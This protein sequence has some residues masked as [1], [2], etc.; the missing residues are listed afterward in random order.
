MRLRSSCRAS[1][2]AVVLLCRGTQP[3]SGRGARAEALRDRLRSITPS[4]QSYIV[5]SNTVCP[6]EALVTSYFWESIDH[7]SNSYMRSRATFV[8]GMTTTAAALSPDLA[9]AYA[10]ALG[11]SSGIDGAVAITSG[12]E[13][14]VAVTRSLPDV[15]A[16]K[17]RRQTLRY[18]WM[19]R[20]VH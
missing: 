18:R 16:N 3:G 1:A 8:I 11:Q 9:P 13:V 15:E 17:K 20:T 10:R 6:A 5:A 7:C 19:A 12:S 2:V 14:H 4:Q